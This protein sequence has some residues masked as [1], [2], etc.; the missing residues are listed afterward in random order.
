[1][2]ETYLYRIQTD[3]NA[4]ANPTA[5]AFF[6]ERVTVDDQVFDKPIASQVSWELGS[7]DTVTV[8]DRTLTYA[9][10]SAF[11]VAIANQV[12]AAQQPA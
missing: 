2:I 12:H 5:T 9:E 7:T 3:P 1:M 6:G 11:L 8:G 4:S 10:V